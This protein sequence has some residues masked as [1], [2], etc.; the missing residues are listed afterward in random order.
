MTANDKDVPAP[1]DD[2]EL[3]LQF[4]MDPFG[5]EPHRRQREIS[6]HY[7]LA[8]ADRAYPRLVQALKANPAA[9]NSPSIIEVLPLFARA[10][11]V[12]LLEAIMN[13]SIEQVSGVAGQA[14]GRHPDASAKDALLRGL[15]SSLPDVMAAAADGLMVR[16]D[17]S[18]CS[19]LKTLLGHKN[20]IVRYHVVQASYKL[21]CLNRDQMEELRR[22]YP[23]LSGLL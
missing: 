21:G 23:E 3:H 5:D 18:V 12:P 19:D 4:L 16:G 1:G 15:A 10:D 17:S 13:R 14:L 8:H 22:A 7:L 20:S 6:V 11:S 9:L 2:I